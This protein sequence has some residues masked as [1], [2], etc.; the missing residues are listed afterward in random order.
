MVPDCSM[1]KLQD[2][3]KRK[4]AKVSIIHSDEWWGYNRTVDLGYRKYYR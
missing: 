4:V 1:E 3:I 2:L